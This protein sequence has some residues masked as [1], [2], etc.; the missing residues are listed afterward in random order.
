MASPGCNH[1]WQ[2]PGM[3]GIKT[4]GGQGEVLISLSR[5]QRLLQFNP[6]VSVTDA[7]KNITGRGQ[8]RAG[9]PSPVPS[10]TAAETPCP[11][12]THPAGTGSRRA[13]ATLVSWH[14]LAAGSSSP[15]QHPSD[16][17]EGARAPSLVQRAL[18]SPA[19]AVCTLCPG[20]AAPPAL[21]ETKQSAEFICAL[22]QAG[23][24]YPPAAPRH[25]TTMHE[26]LLGSPRWLLRVNLII[27][28]WGPRGRSL[29]SSNWKSLFGSQTF[30]IKFNSR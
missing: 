16:P 7:A 23:T 8:G 25:C 20:E 1:C 12:R 4:G 24:P 27:A 19:G 15:H 6:Y 10:S 9:C 17:L 28:P 30:T 18:G 3:K 26:A 22:Q 13:R 2:S 29:F 14:P 21:H 5:L 11:A